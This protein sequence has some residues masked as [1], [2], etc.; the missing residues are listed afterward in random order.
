M[1]KNYLKIA[2][3]N[4]LKHKTYSLL[5]TLGLAIG[6][7][8]FLLIALFVV[9]ELSYDR[10][11][12]KANRIYRINSDIRI[13]GNEMKI[14]ATADVMGELLKKDYPEV[15]NYTRIYTYGGRKLIKKANTFL[16]EKQAYVDSTFFN[17]FTL[18]AIEGST[19]N[20]LSEPNSVVI[21]RSAALKYF[22][23]TNAVG[24]DIETDDK[25]NKFYQVKAVIKDVPENSHFDFDF[26]FPMQDVNYNWGQPTNHNFYTY[27]LLKPGTDPD[28]FDKHFPTYIHDYVFP[29]AQKFM[30]IKNMDEFE[31]AGNGMK[32]SLIPLTKIHLY[33]NRQFEILPGGDI[34]YIYIFSAVAIFILVIAC[35]N[36]MNLTTARSANRSKE[37]GIR[38]VLGSERKYLISQFLTESILIVG[39][40]MLLALVITFL[41]LPA[42]NS[43]SGKSIHISELLSTPFIIL[44][45]LLPVVVGVLAGSYPAFFL[46]AFR[47]IQ[48][49]KGK[50][51]S[52]GKTLGLRS[53]LVVFQFVTSIV[54]II[55]TIVIYRQL[56]YIQH[57][58]L[59]Y[60][61]DEVLV[62]DGTYSLGN[63]V[64]TFKNEVLQL[65]G[66]KNGT[67]S[68]F[69][70]VANTSRSDQTF[71]K[72]AV[73]NSTN[74]LDM[75]KWR[76]DTDYLK[77]LGIE[78]NEGRNFSEKFPS[79]SSAVILNETAAKMLGYND[80]VGEK[81]YT[82]GDDGNAT[83]YSVIGVVKNFNF[84][85]LK[86]EIG[87][88]CF[89]LSR[90]A[91][92]ISFKINAG[93]TQTL[94]PKIENK[95]KS[96]APEMPFTYRFLDQ[97]FEKMYRSEQ[98][99][100]KLAI[101]FSILAIFIAC[102]GLFGLA[103]FIAEQRTKEIGIRKVLGA[104]VKSM[105]GLLSTDFLKLVFI[106][107]IIA[108][109]LALW[110]MHTWLQDF[111]YRTSLSWWIF[112]LAGI[113][114]MLIALTTISFQALRAA[115]A[116]PIKSLRNN[117]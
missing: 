98:R 74:S 54:L 24:K 68:G 36:F 49:L 97:A 61:K 38:K 58:N 11:N 113:L 23:T 39:I 1:W 66:V 77:T 108:I 88:L 12:E 109:P 104:S 72:D 81:L 75:Q 111:A 115:T 112:A 44:I 16:D 106:A 18:P 79:D 50:Q 87:P 10:Y 33:S 86:N 3:R 30:N 9:S 96:L 94:I 21:T 29:A 57:V 67:V 107:F 64:S 80:P 46:S 2:W 14:P 56:N 31:K 114:A 34:K 105:V 59:G 13:G 60:N 78:I 65:T 32:Y 83:S 89:L 117:E 26:F 5:N 8:C 6:L 102:L 62:I 17:I 37:V 84:E 48:V 19:K 43:I 47:P 27:L 28:E 63:N 103:T 42:F 100:G 91:G 4:L 71:S 90:N 101:L 20:A 70:P 15:E 110:G 51:S 55:G 85:S 22:G 76:I 25:E 99:I 41:V 7:S 82:I 35:I 52:G 93:S 92:N 45:I 53:T 40:S 69:L 116:D 95:W 73:M